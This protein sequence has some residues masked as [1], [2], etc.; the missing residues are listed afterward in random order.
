MLKALLPSAKESLAA[1]ARKIQ[2]LEKKSC[3]GEISEIDR[4][5]RDYPESTIPQKVIFESSLRISEDFEPP[6]YLVIL[7]KLSHWSQE[8]IISSLVVST[9]Y[10]GLCECTEMRNNGFRA[11][12]RPKTHNFLK[13]SHIF[14]KLS[15]NY[16]IIISSV[17]GTNYFISGGAYD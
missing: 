2:R 16:L 12:F 17:S 10:C 9:T 1:E 14:S 13:L 4:D 11:F 8:P 7:R 6:N 5:Y 15:R 3:Y